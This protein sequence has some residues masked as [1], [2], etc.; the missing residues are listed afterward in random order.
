MS[1]LRRRLNSLAFRAIAFSTVWAVVALVVIATVI[2]TLF[3]QA[4]ER[5]FESLLTAH[6]FNLISSVGVTDDGR[7]EG[8]PN[9]GDLRFTIPWSGWYWSVEPVSDNVTGQIG[10]LSLIEDI[11]TPSPTAVP[12]SS[13]T[14]AWVFDPPPS[15]P[16]T[17]VLTL[18]SLL[19]RRA[20]PRSS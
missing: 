8:S 4:S 20:R 5:G 13:A 6:L 19:R 2:S 18:P 9:L 14:M 17:I 7:L 12:F 10:S 16:M 11:P 15:I 1:F 3:R